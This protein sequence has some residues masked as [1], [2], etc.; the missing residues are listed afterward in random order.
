MHTYE[1]LKKDIMALGIMPND[2]IKI[3]SSLKSVGEIS[4]GGDTLL[5]VFCD[6]LKDNGLLVL[7]THTWKNT[8]D[9]GFV[10]EPKRTAS[11]LGVLPNL[12]LKRENIHRSLHPTHSV[13]AF[14]KEAES[15]VNCTFPPHT[16]CARDGCYGKL[17]DI[18]AKVLLLGVTLT[19]NTFFH[20]IEETEQKNSG[21][22]SKKPLPTKIKFETG[23]IVDCPVH[24]A[25]YWTSVNFDKAMEIVLAEETTKTG[26]IGD[27]DCILLDCRKIY[28]IIK[29]MLDKEPDIFLRGVSRISEETLKPAD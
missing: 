29:E 23:E 5:D 13:A 19:T 6:Y 28:P 15:F 16:P 7:P 11:N 8:I 4:G 21:I 1:S 3:H 2:K 12:F 25:V 14:G 26:K 10:F 18:G 20:C 27:A 24:Y 22:M 17:Y 9:N